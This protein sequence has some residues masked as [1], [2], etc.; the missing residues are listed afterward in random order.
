MHDAS[1]KDYGAAGNQGARS[2]FGLTGEGVTIAIVDTGVSLGIEEG[3]QHEQL[4]GNTVVGDV[5][6]IDPGTPGDDCNGH[7]THV[8]SI[9]AGNGG[10]PPQ[11]PGSPA[12]G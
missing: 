11:R 6:F 9:A 5:D 1:F 8:A 2:A 12:G 10:A 3:E 4:D 7:G